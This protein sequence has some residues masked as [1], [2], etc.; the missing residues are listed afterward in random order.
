MLSLGPE[1]GAEQLNWTSAAKLPA[2]K[3][4]LKDRLLDAIFLLDFKESDYTDRQRAFLVCSKRWAAGMILLHKNIRQAGI[5]Q[6]EQ[7][8]RHTLHFEFTELSMEIL[9]VLRLHFG[10]I[11]GDLKK[12]AEYEQ[13]LQEQE[14]IWLAERRAESFYIELAVHF[15]NA[16][17]DKS[18]AKQKSIE[19]FSKIKP[20]LDRFSAFK[21][22][23]FGRLIE[24][25][26]HSSQNDYRGMA[27]VC[28]E[29]IAFFK[30]KK[31]DSGLF[32]QVFYYNLI[33]CCLSLR[34]F[35]KG[36]QYILVLERMV[37]TGSFNWFKIQEPYFFY[38]NAYRQLSKGAGSIGACSKR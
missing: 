9:R 13:I 20:C 37:Q 22:H 15:V 16:K 26:I 30:D 36:Q 17:A 33:T 38:C 24:T 2:L 34:Q 27:R 29:A 5:N 23:M 7:L 14:E 10:T 3:S 8:L 31:Y 19:Y 18:A 6:F 28:E 11:E 21:L 12:Y 32:L 25:V 1:L 35:E 4:K